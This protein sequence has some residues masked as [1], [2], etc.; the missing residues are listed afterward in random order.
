MGYPDSPFR[1]A[2][3]RRKRNL[4]AHIVEELG[5]RIVRGEW[6]PGETL[7][8][9]TELGRELGASRSVLREAVKSLAS[10]GLLELQPRTGTRVL[11]CMHWNL[12]DLDV[13]SWRYSAMP[14]EQFF[15]ELF[16]IRM[17]IEPLAAGL[18]A[19]RATPAQVDALS[20]AYAA[21]ER[22]DAEGISCAGIDAGGAAAIDA[23]LRFHRGILTCAHNELL[24]QLGSLIAVGLLTSF[25]ISTRSYHSGLPLHLKVLEAIRARRPIEARQAME[26]LLQRTRRFV[27]RDLGDGYDGRARRLRAVPKTKSE[28]RV[29]RRAAR[30][31]TAKKRE[32]PMTPKTR[33][34]QHG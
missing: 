16:E 17:M 30:K 12:L 29:Q 3:P 19:E 8:N 25:R 14:R 26:E 10:K 4:F 2:A 31:H 28:P 20:A 32:K 9:E 7:P 33:R 27:A 13:L 23:D 24:E 11:P 22:A 18:A 5:S 15:V 6:K 1:Q 21:M 34:G